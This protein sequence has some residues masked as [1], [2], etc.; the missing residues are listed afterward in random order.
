MWSLRFWLV[1]LILLANPVRADELLKLGVLAVRGNTETLAKWQPLADYLNRELPGYRFQLQPL[2]YDEMN[3]AIKR[4]QVD[5]IFSQAGHYINMDVLY[6]L[7]APLATLIERDGAQLLPAYGGAVVIRAER[8]DIRGFADLRGKT[9]VTAGIQGFGGYLMQAYEVYKAGLTIPGD[10]KLLQVGLPIDNAIYALLNGKADAAFVRMGL[11]EQMAR[12]GKLRLDRVKT[13]NPQKLTDSGSVFSTQTY[14]SWPFVALPH[15]PDILSARVA[16]ALLTLPRNGEV[17]RA[18]DIWGFTIPA[19]YDS[20]KEVMQTLRVAPFDQAPAFSLR[21]VWRRYGIFV[22]IFIALSVLNL[23]LLVWLFTNRHQ[24]RIK[25]KLLLDASNYA[26]NLIEASLDSLVTINAA[27]KITDVNKAT[28]TATGYPRGLLIG[29]DFSDYFTDPDNA[30]ASYAEVFTTGS[31]KDY[32]LSIRHISGKIIDVLYN[33][34]VFRD[35]SGQ[36]KGVLAAARD[37]TERRQLEKA[38]SNAYKKNLLLLDSAGEGIYGLDTE[39]LCTFAN[40]A[41]AHMLG[42]EVSALLGLNIHALIHHSHH[43]G[44]P[45]PENQ[46]PIYDVFRTGTSCYVDYEV[47]WRKDQTPV[48]VEYASHPIIDERRVTGAVVTFSDITARKQAEGE[49]EQHRAHLEE[50]VE[51]RARHISILNLQL[52]NRVLEAEQ[53][54]RALQ[55][56][57]TRFRTLYNSIPDPVFITGTD[58]RFADVNQAACEF[59]GYSR[60]ELLSMGP[61]DIVPTEFSEKI[62]YKFNK[63]QEIGHGYF[64]SVHVRK[65]G[66]NIPVELSNTMINLAG[67]TLIISIARNL[68]ERKRAEKILK[69]SELRFSKVFHDSPVGIAIARISDAKFIE[70]NTAFLN[71]LGYTR[72]ETIYRS[73]QELGVWVN[74][75]IREKL[76]AQVIKEG[77]MKNQ[78]ILVKRKTGDIRTLLISLEKIDFYAEPCILGLFTDISER[79]RSEAELMIAK[80]LAEAASNAKSAFL[81]NMSHEIR[82]PMNTIMGMAHLLQK[83]GGLDAQQKNKLDRIVIASNHLLSIINDIL[84]LSKIESGKLTLNIAEFELDKLLDQAADS[85][86]GLAREKQLQLSVANYP[87]TP[88]LI[89]DTTRLTQMLLNYLGNAI[90]FTEQGGVL[91]R[92]LL[93][94]DTVNDQLIRF[95]VEDTGIGVSNEQKER[96]FNAFEQADNSTTRRFG[97][98]GLGL[99][100]NRSLARLMDGE[101]GVESTPG[102]GSTFWFTARLTKAAIAME[103]G[104]P[105]GPGKTAA[106]EDILKQ[107]YAA[108]RILIADDSEFNRILLRELLIGAGFNMDFAENGKIALEL[109]RI[110]HY[111]LIL[112]DMQMPEMGGIE[113][114]QAIRLLPGYAATPIIAVTGNAF[115]KDRLAC[116]D[117]GMNDHISKPIEPDLLY[118]TLLEWLEKTKQSQ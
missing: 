81:S 79:K 8:N 22:L 38:L 28:E 14:P 115:N 12:E 36:V 48:P 42:Y 77:V 27:G 71:I 117:G 5:F 107:K 89:G 85:V 94:E 76:I 13:V 24:L 1:W 88:R 67:K 105:E 45:Y 97:G 20:V 26:R 62:P 83:Q 17:A 75:T 47:F 11:I 43:D 35:E 3:D 33:L 44:S 73:C 103:N 104:V 37:I 100:I 98:T 99:A 50:R 69:E 93:L 109:A 114:T 57:E 16:A 84:D 40:K 82:T 63:L 60:E 118:Q 102:A 96:L 74:P 66:V 86:S 25:R 7:S 4:Q 30:K 72:E 23:S 58:G 31:I 6:P 91:L 110:H 32:P 68:S 65:D 92:A 101:V 55:E 106:A 53:A 64:E 19:R 56:S 18:A 111:D 90:K 70:V 108:A 112:M 54:S 113:A 15:T 80:E 46:C 78:E 52:E 95:E 49:L 51:E 29:S 87:M 61:A 21:D 34:T 9:V 39:G 116:L 59:L 41:A 2:N 10:V